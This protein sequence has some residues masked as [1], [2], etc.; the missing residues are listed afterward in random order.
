MTGSAQSQS[1]QLMEG[2]VYIETI[3]Y[4]KSPILR[5]LIITLFILILYQQTTT[6]TI[7]E[8]FSS[9]CT[10]NH[11]SNQFTCYIIGIQSK[12]VVKMI[13]ISSITTDDV[14]NIIV[15]AVDAKD[16][17]KDAEVYWNDDYIMLLVSKSGLNKLH[18]K[19]GET[20][21]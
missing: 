17:M 15:V 4:F 3:C 14:D 21:P 6:A 2:L 10:W 16:L 8:G 12:D 11:Y 9:N 7:C 19:R 13:P 18:C 5:D 20:L 1:V